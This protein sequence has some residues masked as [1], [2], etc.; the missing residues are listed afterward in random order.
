MLVPLPIAVGVFVVA[1]PCTLWLAIRLIGLFV[2]LFS[3]GRKHRRS[4]SR[5]THR[6][7]TPQRPVRG[8]AEKNGRPR[9]A[10][11]LGRV[12]VTVALDTPAGGA[13]FS[14]VPREANSNVADKRV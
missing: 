3:G 2:E 9:S 6:R 10:E 4:R 8:S 7:R 13:E 14:D 12:G 11:E 5:V 1:I